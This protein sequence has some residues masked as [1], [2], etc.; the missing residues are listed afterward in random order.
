MDPLSQGV[1]GASLSQSGSTR[2]RVVAAGVL[3]LLGGMAPDLDVLIRSSHDPLLALEHHRQFTHSLIFIPVGSLICALVAHPLAGRWLTFRENWLF[4]LLGYATHGLL[5]ACTSYGTQLLWPFSDARIAWNSV[6][7][8]DPLFT[9]PILLLVAIAALRRRPGAA[10]WALTWGVSYLLLGA[11]QHHRALAAGEVLAASRGHTP[12]RLEAKPS[13]ANLLVW[14]TVYEHA[15]RYYVDAARVAFEP[16]VFAGTSTPMLRLS[17][18]FPWLDADSRQARDVERFRRFSD[19]FVAV[20]PRQPNRI[21]DIRYSL[22]PN[23]IDALWGIELDPD[24]PQQH[25]DF[26]TARGDSSQG[27]RKL[28]QMLKSP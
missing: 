6:S 3:G 18:D 9:L 20:D 23:E 10:R 26:F 21:V 14:K 25:V 2:E 19:G 4:C 28:L 27:A 15:G 12:Q 8:V 22:V 16:R 17:Q 7:V 13:F 24:A 5:D 1:L 11:F